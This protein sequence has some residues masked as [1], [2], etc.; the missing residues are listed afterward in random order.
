MRV[1]QHGWMFAALAL[2]MAGCTSLRT[3]ITKERSLLEADR[4][5]AEMSVQ[6]GAG[7]A[8]AAMLSPQTSMLS[9][10]EGEYLGAAQAAQAFPNRPGQGDV[11]YWEADKAWIAADD[12]LGVT[13]G[14]FV[15]TLNGA[16]IEQGRYVTIWRRDAGGSWKAELALSN[17]DTPAP[18]GGVNAPSQSPFL[19]GVGGLPPDSLGAPVRRNGA[20]PKTN[21][22]PARRR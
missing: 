20:A 21:G 10:P 2:A 8:M 11:L 4:R 19:P 9:R 14:R 6:Q 13:T 22:T 1:R 3:E 17:N 12:N 7:V 15:R 18:A 5:Y 16:Q